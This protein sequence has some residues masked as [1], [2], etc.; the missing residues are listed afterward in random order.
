MVRMKMLDD[1][2][3]N[4]CVE[5][6]LMKVDGRMFGMELTLHFLHFAGSVRQCNNNGSF[7][8]CGLPRIADDD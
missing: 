8:S 3:E 2:N 4:G 1:R 6:R 5:T 7:E